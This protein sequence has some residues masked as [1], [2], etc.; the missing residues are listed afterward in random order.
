MEKKRKKIKTLHPEVHNEIQGEGKLKNVV[1]DS[2]SRSI[3]ANNV[4]PEKSLSRDVETNEIRIGNQS[5]E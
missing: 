2:R 3:D 4:L 1:K 5:I